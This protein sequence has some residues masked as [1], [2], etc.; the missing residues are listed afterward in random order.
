MHTWTYYIIMSRSDISILVHR[1]DWSSIQCHQVLA[2]YGK[3]VRQRF[4]DKLQGDNEFPT[5]KGHIELSQ[6]NVE[7]P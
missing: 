6:D 2:Q 7:V 5:D 1:Y 3:A 4:P